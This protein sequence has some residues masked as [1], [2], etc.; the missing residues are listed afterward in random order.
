MTLTKSQEGELLH[1]HAEKLFHA[2]AVALPSLEPAPP[3]VFSRQR[4]EWAIMQLKK[5]K[6]VPA[7]SA[8][9]TTWQT[10]SR[11]HS[12]SLEAI[13][14]NTLCS[15]R[16]FIPSLWTRV[17]LAW[18][19]KPGK[20]PSCPEHLRSIGLMGVDTKAFM[21]ILKSE[22]HPYIRNALQHTPQFAYRSG[23]PFCG[24]VTIVAWRGEILRALPLRIS[25]R[26]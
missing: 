2:D 9:I 19:P 7:G 20:T 21:V 13:C 26:T 15:G 22:A 24:L 8:Q 14:R 6:A 18:L 11:E 5:G 23:V 17:Q 12:I 4:W 16:P 25:P 3:E 10:A 1:K